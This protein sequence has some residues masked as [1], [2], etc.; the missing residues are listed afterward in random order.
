MVRISPRWTGGA[1]EDGNRRGRRAPRDLAQEDAPRLG[2]PG[3]LGERLAVHRLA[4]H[5]DVD[6][7]HRHVQQ[8]GV[9]DL[10]G[11]LSD[12][13]HEHLAG[14]GQRE[15]VPFTNHGVG[16]RVLDL[17]IAAADPLDED[18]RIGHQRLG[19][20]GA[21][22][23]GLP[24]RPHAEGPELPAVPGGAGAA[25]LLGAALLGLVIL[26]GGDKIDA[27]QPRAD[28]GDHDRRADGAEQVGHRVRD[29]HR[30]DQS[31]GLIGRHAQLVDG[32]GREA[33]RGG[34]R[35]RPRVEAR[36][37]AEVVADELD[38]RDGHHQAEQALDHR[39][40]CLRQAVLGDTAHELRPDAVAHGEQE[41]EEHGRLERLRDRD[42][43]LTDDDA[44]QQGGGDRPQ[45]DASEGELAEVVP[46]GERE[47]DRDLGIGPQRSEE[48]VDHGALRSPVLSSSVRKSLAPATI[49][50]KAS[51]PSRSRSGASRSPVMM[52]EVSRPSSHCRGPTASGA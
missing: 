13:L 23:D 48:P 10:L 4:G 44:G 35:L 11:G 31:L 42:P 7:L 20:D 30:V 28:Q 47:E 9:V 26:G 45:P 52:A 24:A 16:G 43:D 12:H 5:V 38:D 40:E 6:A 50:L 19:L 2:E 14:A 41:H 18:P 25:H 33:H 21:E 3:Q 32:V 51:V 15:H 27:E 34:Q 17:S 1:R 29:G 39:E 8:L 46:E 49:P 37:V 36:R 22:A